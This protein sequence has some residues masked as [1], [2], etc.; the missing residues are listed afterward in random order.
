MTTP[1]SNLGQQTRRSF[2]NSKNNASLVGSGPG[3]KKLD[4]CWSFNKG[5]RCKFGKKCKFIKRCSYCDS[6]VHGVVN[7]DC[8]LWKRE[9]VALPKEKME[10]NTSL[11]KYGK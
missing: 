6:T 1:L 3:K 4:N 5:V 8:Q 9:I 10:E 2:G 7:C 11:N